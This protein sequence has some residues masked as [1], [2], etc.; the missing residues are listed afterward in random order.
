MALNIVI[1]AAGLG[2]RMYS[3]MPKV[4]HHIGGRSLISQVL[5]TAFLLMPSK[6][7]VVYGHHGEKVKNKVMQDFPNNEICWVYQEQQLGTA[8]AL[9]C[10]LPYLDSNSATLLLYGDVPL[11]SQETLDK[12]LDKY[13]GSNVVMLSA[14]T[15]NPEGYGRVIRNESFEIMK[16]VEHKDA[17]QSERCINEINSGIYLFSNNFLATW[18]GKINNN[19]KSG[20]YYVTDLIAIAYD[21]GVGIE[22]VTTNKLY[23]ILGVNN[24]RQ[25]E[26]LERLLQVKQANELLEKGVMLYDK[27]RI[28]I[29][30]NLEVGVD[31]VIDVGCIF[32]GEVVIGNQVAI[33]AYVI[34]KNVIIHDGVTIKPY[35]IIEGAEIKHQA[36]I[37]PF[38]R[39]RPTSTINA[40]AHIG[41]FVEVKNTE[42]GDNSKAN[43]LTY[44]GD[45]KVGGGVNVGAGTVTCN[46]DGKNKFVTNIE[47]NVFIGSGTM[48][49]APVT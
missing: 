18:L 16:I 1:L 36:Q 47:D 13:D 11:I 12:M 26:N 35:S 17:S 38:S 40:H 6:I 2:K 25:L 41:N 30:G 42:L 44:L 34:L 29:R 10:A 19:N 9:K 46:Y 21:N 15:V 49:V 4:L 33:G 3:D 39:V 28:D 24:K 8:H 37:G 23:E 22:S 32:E 43:H 14:D 20:E 31:C 48:L 45:A 5:K 27:T 7:I